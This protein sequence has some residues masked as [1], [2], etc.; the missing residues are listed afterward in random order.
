MKLSP[1]L[2]VA[3]GDL[4]PNPLSL[5]HQYNLGIADLTS[6]N[7]Y[8]IYTELSQRRRICDLQKSMHWPYMD[9]NRDRRRPIRKPREIYIS[10][11]FS[12]SLPFWL[13]FV[14]YEIK[15]FGNRNWKY[16][17]F[18][19]STLEILTPVENSQS[20]SA[21]WGTSFFVRKFS[22]ERV[23]RQTNTFNLKN[24]EVS[25]WVSKWK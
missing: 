6:D 20:H 23:Q 18:R 5:S 24:A 15:S 19:K 10:L 17:L 1:S 2:K 25:S 7:L 21:G 16:V 12:K 11:C 13:N 3:G 14:Q 4:H 9:S 22:K 8:W